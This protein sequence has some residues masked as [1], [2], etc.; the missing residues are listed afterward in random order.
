M[1][2]G[3]KTLLHIWVRNGWM[4]IHD[5]LILSS[6]LVLDSRCGSLAYASVGAK[7]SKLTGMMFL[8]PPTPDSVD[9]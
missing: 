8:V 5:P 6:S 3:E 1:L 7:G 9:V 4:Y 2:L